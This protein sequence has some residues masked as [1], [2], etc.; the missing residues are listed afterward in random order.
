MLEENFKQ[1]KSNI[2]NSLKEE[3]L[4]LVLKKLFVKDFNV[5]IGST[6]ER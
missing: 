3:N 2:Q 1:K 6:E 4:I 5:N